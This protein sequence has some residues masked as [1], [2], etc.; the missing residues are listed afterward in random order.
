MFSMLSR[1]A[2]ALAALAAAQQAAL[3][4]P[5]SAIWP[6]GA[7]APATAAAMTV[8]STPTTL[9]VAKV[10][11]TPA[12]L[13]VAQLP[14]PPPPPGGPAIAA[15]AAGCTG[16]VDPYKNYACLDAYLGEGF[17]ERL[18][19]YYRLEYGESGPPTDPNAPEGRRADW[20]RTPA[21]TPPMPFT[22][23]PYG[24]TQNLGVTRPS[25]TDSPFMVAIANTPAGQWMNDNH[26]QLYGWIDAG[27]NVSSNSIRPGGNAPINYSYT[28]NTVQLDQAVIYF[29]RVPD[30]VQ[31]VSGSPGSMARTIAIRL[32]TA[33]RVTS[34]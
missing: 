27:F 24:G 28:P 17:F 18:S 21:T 11:T 19:N 3:A 33:S 8:P 15:P 9:P 26:I 23:W 30:T 7:D 13:L 25:S 14:P 6:L 22:E 4:E 34:F 16:P 31:R 1:A 12:P 20:P 2:L 29:E 32:P 10:P 5:S